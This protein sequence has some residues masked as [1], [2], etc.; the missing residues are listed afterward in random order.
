MGRPAC[1]LG[2]I[3]LLQATTAAAEPTALD[4]LLARTDKVAKEVAKIRGL[5]LKKPIPNEVVDKD[6]L[7]KRLLALASEEKTQRETAAEGLAL[8][9]WGLIPLATDYTALLIDLLTEQVAGYYDPETKKLTISKS[10]GDDPAWAELVLAHEIDHGLQDQ[11]FD[12][13]KFEDLPDT[14]GDASAARR[15]LV[16]GDGIA[17][18]IEVMLARQ[19]TAAP[20]SNPEVTAAIEKAMTVPGNGDALDKAPLAIRESLIFPYRAGLSFVAALRRR[21]PWSAVDA[22]YARPPSSTEQV[23]HPERYLAKDEP[24]PIAI[25]TPNALRDHTVVHDT[26]WG[27]LSWNL[28]LRT[29][30]VDGATATLASEGWGGDR[31]ITLARGKDT[32]P[33]RAVGIARMEWDSE[34]DAIEAAEAAEK[35]LDM[36]IAG[37]TVDHDAQ[38][39]RW[40]ALDGTVSWIE[41]RGPSLV[42]VIGAPAYSADALAT[43]VWT[44]SSIK[45]P[46]AKTAKTAK[47]AKPR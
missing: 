44:A 20:W 23:I 15:A 33:Q 25:T 28:F 46:A 19:G 30:G 38:R 14:E 1:A 5:K 18:M 3:A 37:A 6:E 10:A 17:L 26:V 11:A 16:E 8:A 43:E 36:M 7:R 4:K 40:M 32:S 34:P 13:K 41:R 27:E 39:T 42:L 35:A 45:A 22:A 47:T 29:H 24:I 31:V 2:L 12:L 21:Q 9:R